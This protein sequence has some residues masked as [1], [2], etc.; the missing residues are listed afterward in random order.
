[1]SDKSAEIR[2]ALQQIIG[3]NPNYPIHATI[4]AVSGQT[5]SVKLVSGLEVSDVRLKATITDGDDY[6]LITP[7]VGSDVLLLSGDGTLRSLTV[8]HVDKASKFQYS[9]NGLEVL[10][11]STDKKVRIQNDEANL[12]D[13]FSDLALL[14][15]QLKHYTPAG[16]SGTPLPDSIQRI[17]A[18]TTKFNKLLK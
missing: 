6:F 2:K 10:F 8:I 4:T 1:M 14:L 15:K 7:D 13:L 16:P 18:W 11:D 17:D 3:A 9:Q 12:K 5:C